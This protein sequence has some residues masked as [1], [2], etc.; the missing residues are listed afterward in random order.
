MLGANNGVLQGGA[1]F[2][3]GKVGQ[4]FNFNP[5]SGT[6][7]VPDSSSLRLT[8]Q[9]TIEA[10]INTQG[11]STDYGIV[12]KVGGVTGNNGYQ[13]ALSGNTLIGQFN[14][15]GQSWPSAKITSGGIIATG[16]W[17][18]VAWTY[19]QSAMKLYCNGALV[20]TQCHWGRGYCC[21]EQQ[22]AH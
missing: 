16:T 19:D 5:A 12:S 6:V 15:P 7:I 20:A 14:S 17:Y 3:K 21:F 13:L 2:A 10:W 18:H 11:T 22:S 9:L 4:A 1:V 8:N